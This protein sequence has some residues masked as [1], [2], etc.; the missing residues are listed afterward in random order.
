MKHFTRVVVRLAGI[1]AALIV[2][3][4][5]YSKKGPFI[6]NTTPP[7]VSA[8]LLNGIE[9]YLNSGAAKSGVPLISWFGPY[10]VNTSSAFFNHNLKDASGAS[11]TPTLVIPYVDGTSSGT[12]VA[13]SD[14]GSMTSTQVKLTSNLG[15]GATVYGIALKF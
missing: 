7:G 2:S 9:N 8:S 3:V 6:D 4:A 15:S 13:T 10:T 1:A 5:F 14:H 12:N 11:I